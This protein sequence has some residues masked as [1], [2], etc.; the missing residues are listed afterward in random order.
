MAI[1][2][3][4]IGAGDIGFSHIKRITED[5]HGGRIVAVSD[6]N[7]E[8]AVRARQLCGARIAPDG[9]SL[10]ADSAVDAVIVASWDA[11]HEEYVLA[12]IGAG[13]HVLCEKPL[14]TDTQSCCRIVEAEMAAGR[15][16]VKL[17]FMRRYDE[18]YVA[19]KHAMYGSVGQPLIVH[20]A[21]RNKA[22]YAQHSTENSVK[23]STV[24]EIDLMRWMLGEDM[25]T[26]QVFAGRAS[27][28]GGPD[29]KDPLTVLLESE[30]GVRVDVE[31][32]INS[33]IG[34][35]VHCSVVGE[36]GVADMPEPARLHL[37]VNNHK[38]DFISDDWKVRFYHAYNALFQ[39]WM[40]EVAAEKLSGPTAWDGL[41][42]T[43][44][45]ERCVDALNSGAIETIAPL[46][47]PKFYRE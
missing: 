12:A 6:V 11:T 45:A 27:A 36:N 1:G 35:E 30:S 25:R 24:H 2:I 39:Q 40:D 5:L 20:C 21:H 28:R 37:R 4:V 41:M 10:I 3:G 7:M 31:V 19:L 47:M 13:K 8:N 46:E 14:S 23:N 34:Y 38:T 16:L 22:G 33:G 15:R 29:L 9:A 32:F 43:Y 26:A 42:A 17:G 44:T 18:G